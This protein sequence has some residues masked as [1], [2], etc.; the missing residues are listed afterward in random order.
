M[1]DRPGNAGAHKYC[2]L[3]GEFHKK[4]PFYELSG[5]TECFMAYSDN[6]G[7]TGLLQTQGNCYPK[8][9]CNSPQLPALL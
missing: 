8:P 4:F 3:S 6:R 2:L 5:L 1:S 7:G 9:T